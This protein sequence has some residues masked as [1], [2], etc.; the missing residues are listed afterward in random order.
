MISTCF[1]KTSNQC[2]VKPSTQIHFRSTQPL[3]C[4]N[5]G[6]S[7]KDVLICE[8]L[9]ARHC[10]QAN[11]QIQRCYAGSIRNL[12]SVPNNEA[13]PTMCLFPHKMAYKLVSGRG[14]HDV[15]WPV[16]LCHR[17]G[18]LLDEDKVGRSR[19]AS[20]TWSSD[21]INWVYFRCEV[22]RAPWKVSYRTSQH[23]SRA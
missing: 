13:A 1:T 6:S 4:E 19:A 5:L 16:S 8:S 7:R 9:R 2:K 3:V 14:P 11:L 10:W 23:Y 20:T 15:T 12:N 18:I 21:E 17:F 22:S